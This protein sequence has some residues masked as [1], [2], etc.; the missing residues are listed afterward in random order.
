VNRI[1]RHEALQDNLY[2]VIEFCFLIVIVIYTILE[3][4]NTLVTPL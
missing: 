4:C 1:S 2:V 3:V